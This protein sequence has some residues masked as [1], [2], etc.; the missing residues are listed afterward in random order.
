MRLMIRVI[1]WKDMAVSGVGVYLGAFVAYITGVISLD[2]LFYCVLTFTLTCIWIYRFL[3][4]P[5]DNYWHVWRNLLLDQQK[6]G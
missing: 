3:G 5:I 2:G 1:E 6:N 4:K